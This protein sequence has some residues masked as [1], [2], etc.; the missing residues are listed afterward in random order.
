MC[1]WTR[2]EVIAFTDREISLV[3]CRA[4]KIMGA[5]GHAGDNSSP[6]QNEAIGNEPIF[7]ENTKKLSFQQCVP[8]SHAPKQLATGGVN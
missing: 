6:I 4:P 1:S 2:A 8:E 3:A 5:G 7:Y